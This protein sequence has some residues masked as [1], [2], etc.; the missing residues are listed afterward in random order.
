MNLGWFHVAIITMIA[1][2][3]AN[4]QPRPSTVLQASHAHNTNQLIQQFLL[5]EEQ[6][7]I[8]VSISDLISDP[9]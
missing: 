3:L 4:F 1:V 9:L 6:V 7:K 8:R 2:T 5:E